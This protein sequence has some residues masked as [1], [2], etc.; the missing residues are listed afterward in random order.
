VVIF[1]PRP[2]Y[3]QGKSLWY[4]FDRRLDGPQSCSSTTTTTTTTTTNNN[5]N[6]K[7]K[8]KKKKGKVKFVPVLN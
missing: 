7:K 6:K 8:K 5:N 1:T 4:P 3:L 2:L